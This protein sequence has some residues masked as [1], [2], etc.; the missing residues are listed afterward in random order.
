MSK[1]AMW[2]RGA[3][4]VAI[5]IGVAAQP[6]MHKAFD[7]AAVVEVLL[8]GAVAARAFVDKSTSQVPEPEP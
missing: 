7:R 3:L 5:A 1:A 4:T 8:A 6:Y 2:L